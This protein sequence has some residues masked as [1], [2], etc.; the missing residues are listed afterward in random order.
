M[1]IPRSCRSFCSSLRVVGLH[2]KVH[3]LDLEER[4]EEMGTIKESFLLI[5]L[6]LLYCQS[7]SGDSDSRFPNWVTGTLH[8]FSEASVRMDPVPSCKI[9][10]T[11]RCHCT[12]DVME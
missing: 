1:V 12:G 2:R 8:Y 3:W 4:K 5:V 9:V 11:E 7:I 10:C 6:V